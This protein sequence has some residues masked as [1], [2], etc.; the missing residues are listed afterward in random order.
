[1]KVV[2]FAGSPRKDGNTDVLVQQVLD[3]AM[4][5][6]ADVEKFYI[7]DM[8]IKGCQGCNYC[9]SVDGCKIDDD[10]TKAYEALRD[11]DGFV[12]GSPIYFFQ[13]TGQMRQFIDRCFA[14]LNPDLIS[15]LEAGKKAVIVGAHGAPDVGAFNTV[16][17][18]FSQILQMFGM[19]V[20]GTFV[21]IGH[22]APGEVKENTGLM[23][24]AK[25]AGTKIFD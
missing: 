21:D 1:M 3:G 16:Y 20:K 4:E 10:M 7:N 18:E 14:L 5:A 6:G 24:Q 13:L 11:A 15:R 17:A 12:F 23:E 22:H 25:I 9:R 2:G 8:N 19:D